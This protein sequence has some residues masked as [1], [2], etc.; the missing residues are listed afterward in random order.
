MEAG[1]KD[2]LRIARRFCIWPPNDECR[3]FIRIIKI[4][5]LFCLTPA[6]E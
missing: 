1:E 2:R 5:Q 6:A 4:W 3:F